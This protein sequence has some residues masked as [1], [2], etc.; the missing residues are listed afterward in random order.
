[1]IRERAQDRGFK[2]FGARGSELETD[3]P[4]GVVRQLFE[5]EVLDEVRRA[6]AL[7]D[8]AAPAEAVFDV[9]SASPERP[10]GEDVSFSALH[11][12]YWMVHNLSADE[13]MLL[14]VDDLHW[15][16]RPSLRFLAYLT[17]RLDGTV[18]G[19]LT[20]LRST[21]PGTDPGLVADIAGD[22]SAVAIRPGPLSAD[23]VGQ[24]VESRLEQIADEQFR[25]ACRRVTGGNPLLL[26]QLLSALALEGSSPGA[27]DAEAIAAVGPRAVSRTVLL[28]LSRLPPK[29]TEVARA[30]AILGEGTDVR[31]I[32]A[33]SG[34][35][36]SGVARVTG[37]L[38]RAEILRSGEPLG[39]VHPLVRDAIYEDVPPGERQLQ[40]A[41]AAKLMAASGASTDQVA[42]QLLVAPPSGEEWVVTKLLEAARAANAKGAPDSASTYLKRLLEEPLDGPTRAD[43]VF[44]LGMAEVHS[45][46]G[47]AAD[48]L[49]E[50]FETL[51]DPERRAHAAYALARTKMFMGSPGEAVSLARR[52]ATEVPPEFDDARRMIESIE[53]ASALWDAEVPDLAQRLEG[54]RSAQLQPGAGAKMLAAVSA[55]DWA[56]RDG[57]CDECAELALAA[58]DGDELM[59]A[60]NGLLWVAANLVL[61][62]G[63][64]P[65]SVAKWERALARAHRNGSLFG[66]LTVHLW[67]GFTLLQRG[68]LPE[69]ETALLASLEEMELWWQQSDA[70][71]FHYPV[72]FYA[73]VLLEQGRAEQARTVLTSVPPPVDSAEGSNLWRRAEIELLLFER[74]SVEA[75]EAAERL[76]SRARWVENPAEI[77]WRSLQAQA[78]DQLG[79]GDE[80]LSLLD[81]ELSLARRWGAPATIGRVL[82]IR[83]V[84]QREHGFDDLRE[85]VATLEDSLSRLE[86]AKALAA[87]GSA[88]RRDRKP[89]DSREPLARAY[90]LAELCGA[91]GLAAE[92]RTELHASGARPRSSALKG[93]ASLTASERRVA[94]LAV[95]GRTNK[96]IAQ[97]LYVTPKT[98]EVHL[99]NAYRK[100]EISS[101]AEL[102]SVLQG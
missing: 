72:G 42:A 6:V 84:V 26:R 12:L 69:A 59:D 13:P 70:F 29:A 92:V 28:R 9:P 102:Q 51:T 93:P 78:L 36:P 96:Q 11:G 54:Y 71:V 95:E 79:R 50:A 40:H 97:A 45:Q 35:E 63:D 52:A 27:I 94:D 68:D 57:R 80:A 23:A 16:D 74:R 48:H 10:D 53:L 75:L 61:V 32:A 91:A 31:S 49:Q 100:L 7:A 73:R 39:F 56:L 34:H 8:A 64:R 25:G 85:S 81:E 41:R 76:R 1:M 2:V 38:A 20:G 19:L 58:L 46:G 24:V 66:I 89:S 98:V 86:L 5:V 15:C 77:P 55:F 43:A 101:R 90:E 17:H 62:L 21:D 88:L 4:F 44:E 60:D 99:S 22:P 47:A 82:R 87:L 37:A 67:L 30:V 14:V 33:L 83:G 3:F 65:E 18:I